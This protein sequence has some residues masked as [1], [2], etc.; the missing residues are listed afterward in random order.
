MQHNPTLAEKL[1]GEFLPFIIM[2]IGLTML[3]W[4]YVVGDLVMG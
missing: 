2:G 1:T 4:V 3:A